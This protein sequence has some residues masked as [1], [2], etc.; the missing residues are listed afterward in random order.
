MSMEQR[1]TDT[2]QSIQELHARLSILLLGALPLS[3]REV[4]GLQN[5]ILVS[6]VTC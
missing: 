5:C 2:L 6:Y 3:F 4:F 1:K